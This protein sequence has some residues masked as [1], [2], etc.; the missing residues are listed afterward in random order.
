M[1]NETKKLL[2]KKLI[3]KDLHSFSSL[4]K[5]IDISPAVLSRK[6]NGHTDFTREE[7]KDIKQCLSLTAEEVC[8]IFLN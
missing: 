3:D 5:A 6:L 4:A 7:I 2:L 1:N 8:N